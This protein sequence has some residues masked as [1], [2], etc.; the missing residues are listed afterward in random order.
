M[1]RKFWRSL[2]PTVL[3]NF[4]NLPFNQAVKLPIWVY[5]MDCISQKGCIVIDSEHIFRGMIQLGF[6]RAATYPNTGIIWRNNGK[7][8]FRGRC[9]IGNDC[10]VIV[11]EKGTLT[12]GNNF[13]VN[14]GMKLVSECS[15]TFGNDTLLG[16]SVT[17][18]DTN[19]H[20]LFDVEK[21][22]FKR[23]FSPIVI[24]N[25]NWFGS[26]CYIMHGVITPDN[27]T[28]GACSVVT[29]S[30][31]FESYCVHGGNPLRVLSRNVMRDH[32]HYAITDYTYE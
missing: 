26:Q 10:Y 25:N 27:C 9:I 19:F 28:F 23:A 16:W 15:I 5:K 31:H 8:I 12:F 3:F 21:K 2:I 7:V 22:S 20:P 4:R 13:I 30:G 1:K 32:N 17:C 18:M 24:G 6:P 29:R 14:C 11:G